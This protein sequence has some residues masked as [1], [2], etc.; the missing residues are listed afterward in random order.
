M[1]T[2]ITLQEFILE[3]QWNSE[4]FPSELYDILQSLHQ[5]TKKIQFT[6]R[7]P[8]QSF[9]Q[10]TDWR[11]REKEMDL[12]ANRQLLM[13]LGNTASVAG[14]ASEEM[15]DFHTFDSKTPLT[16]EYIVVA[17]PLD[18]S[19]NLSCNGSSGTIF[20][21]YKRISSGHI[22]SE[23]DFMQPGKQLVAAGYV[24]FGPATVL[25]YSTGNGVHVF[26]YDHELGV[27]CLEQS[28]VKIPNP[29]MYY[30]INES[31]DFTFPPAIRHFLKFAKIHDPE[32]LRPMQHRYSGA[33]VADFHRILMHGGIFM[34][35]PTA[36]HERG[37]LRL[38][39]ECNP[40]AFLASQADGKASD[41]F[42]EILNK[43]VHHLHERCPFYIGSARNIEVL[44]NLFRNKNRIS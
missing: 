38:V 1:K 36:K 43:K 41:G 35:P 4:F 40:L 10:A 42:S 17:D 28:H 14:Y 30:C 26:T 33:L 20:G 8:Q 11:S 13:A 44:E 24:L 32:D 18:G 12:Y 21:I 9:E 23:L 25:V 22:V 3:E 7:R 15:E 31:H 6:L 2:A 39:Y 19:S 27:Y 37:K 29:G 5:A 16:G 34:Y